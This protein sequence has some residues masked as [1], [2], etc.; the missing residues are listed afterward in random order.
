[1]EEL[2]L[3]IHDMNNTYR[4]CRRILSESFPNENLNDSF[5]IFSQIYN[6]FGARLHHGMKN[7]VN[8]L[9]KTKALHII[10]PHITM[11]NY[12][13]STNGKGLELF[14][15]DKYPK[16][17]QLFNE[18][19]KAT[20]EIIENT[21]SSFDF[22]KFLDK[23]IYSYLTGLFIR[24]LN[25][26]DFIESN[27]YNV[28][29]IP[30]IKENPIDLNYQEPTHYSD[31]TAS[32]FA[33]FPITF[34]LFENGSNKP[35]IK[36]KVENQ[37]IEKENANQMIVHDDDNEYDKVVQLIDDYAYELEQFLKRFS[38]SRPSTIKRSKSIY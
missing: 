12:I 25:L 7:A 15:N 1:M 3:L 17:K 13:K 27:N 19:I 4:V 16:F 32:K 11:E 33:N 23:Q 36:M 2:N 26:F 8:A 28:S 24:S 34:G 21:K 37:N 29:I 35:I 9:G 5:D 20:K 22:K 31:E 18:I 6:L 30:F 10:E 38:M 14:Q